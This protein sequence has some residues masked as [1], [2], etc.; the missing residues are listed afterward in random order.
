MNL[1]RIIKKWFK[2]DLNRVKSRQQR[3]HLKVEFEGRKLAVMQCIDIVAARMPE[4]LNKHNGKRVNH[5]ENLKAIYYKQ[6]FDEMKRYAE[7][8]LSVKNKN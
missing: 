8:V 4:M 6:G 3:R 2:S 7:R 5:R 1:V